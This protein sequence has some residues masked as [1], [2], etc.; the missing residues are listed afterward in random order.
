MS[1]RYKG[2]WRISLSLTTCSELEKNSS[3]KKNAH[4]FVAALEVQNL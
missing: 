4:K 2:V 3:R 1:D